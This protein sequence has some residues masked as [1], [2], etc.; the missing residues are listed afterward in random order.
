MTDQMSGT[1]IETIRVTD[2]VFHLI[3]LHLM[4]ME[5]TC[6]EVYGCGAPDLK[7]SID[8]IPHTLREGTVKCRIRYSRSIDSVEFEH[9]NPRQIKTLKTIVC[10]D[11]DYHLKYS[12]RTML[13]AIKTQRGDADEVIIVRDG[14][15]TDTTYSNLLFKA[16]NRL[17]TPSRPLL[18]GIMR[19]FLIS[20][21]IAEEYDITP[22]MLRPGNKTGISGV[23]L[24]NAMLP[25]DTHS[26]L[27]LDCISF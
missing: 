15:V 14:L 13:D 3:P 11:I 21:G 9:Y 23:I 22:E 10:D 1:F 27:P 20:R 6:R 5:S 4:R 17:I 26:P 19:H 25:P 12:D 7:L 24:I 2:G 18:K 16:G 8:N